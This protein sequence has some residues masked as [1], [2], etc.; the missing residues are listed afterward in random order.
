VHVV[1]QPPPHQRPPDDAGTELVER[2]RQAGQAAP[3]VT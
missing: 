2:P 3:I 1:D